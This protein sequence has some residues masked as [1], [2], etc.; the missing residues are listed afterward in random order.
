MDDANKTGHRTVGSTFGTCVGLFFLAGF[1]RFLVAFRTTMELKWISDR[2]SK[3]EGADGSS[4]DCCGNQER[5]TRFS[6]K[7]DILRGLLEGL[8]SFVG[9]LL[10][11][12]VRIL[13]R[14]TIMI[15]N[16]SQFYSRSR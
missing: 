3:N 2:G 8:T 7:T 13:L 12:V 1:Y 6:F 4:D 14:Y 15:N 16:V 11:L 5:T 9:Y 10:M